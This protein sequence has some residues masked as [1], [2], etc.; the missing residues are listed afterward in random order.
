ME[1]PRRSEYTPNDLLSFRESET[2]EITPKFQRRGVWRLPQ[3]SYFIDTVLRQMPVPP[4]YLRETQSEDFTKTV[5]QVI[6]G[7][8][9]IRAVLEYIDGDYAISRSVPGPWAGKSFSR[10]ALDE[11]ERVRNFHFPAEVFIGISDAEVLDIFARMNTYSIQLNKQELR[12]GKYFG[13]FKT[14]CYELAHEHLEFWRE[15]RVFTEQGI[16]R[17]LE[18]ELASECMIFTMDGPQDKK[19]SID[20][21][22]ADFDE[23]FGAAKNVSSKF[24]GTID[25]IAELVAPDALRETA[26]RGVPLFYSLFGAVHHARYGANMKAPSYGRALSKAEKESLRAAILRLSDVVQSARADESVPKKYQRFVTAC[27]RQTDNI[28]PRRTRIETILREGGVG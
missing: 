10:L 19:S 23:E 18:V 5:R 20:R 25:L 16:A 28:Q 26:F 21:F 13:R 24:R 3:R 9:R 17:M 12:N 14:T 4:V 2:L 27:L 22:Y 7:Q 8:Q 1:R 11:Q 15:A 6:D